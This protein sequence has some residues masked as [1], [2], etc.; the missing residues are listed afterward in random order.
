MRRPL[1]P[2]LTLLLA[3]LGS[4]AEAA[5]EK[6]DVQALLEHAI[7]PP[8][9]SMAEVQDYTEARVP[10]MPQATTDEAWQPTGQTD[11]AGRAGQGRLSRRGG[12]LA[13]G[14]DPRRVA[15][16]HRRRAGIPHPQAAL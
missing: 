15:G 8:E 7:L 5:E 4:A 2:A 12:P 10:K 9:L 1:A 13:H 6:S 16:H 3:A 14:P 11:A